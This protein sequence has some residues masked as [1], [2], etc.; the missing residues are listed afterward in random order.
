MGLKNASEK[1]RGR[2]A[3]VE[4]ELK[5]GLTDPEGLPGAS[6]TWP[7][8]C[9]MPFEVDENFGGRPFLRLWVLFGGKSA[10]QFWA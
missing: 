4:S 3:K 5:M 2:Q 8:H 9:F 6:A 1:Q 7:R 10:G